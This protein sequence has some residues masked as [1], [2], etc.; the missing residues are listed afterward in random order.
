LTLHLKNHFPFEPTSDQEV[1]IQKIEDF[2][3][4]LHKRSALVIKG[5]AGTGKTTL[6]GSLVKALNSQ[7]TPVILMAPTGRA[8][9]VMSEYSQ[10]IATTIHRGIYLFDNKDDSFGFSLK[11]N[12]LKNA[13]VI[14]D[15]SS[16]ISSSGGL[17]SSFLAPGQTL[18]D[19][20][21]Q[22]VFNDYNNKLILVGDDAQLPPVGS[23]Y[24]PA[25]NIDFLQREL[26][27]H[28][29]LAELHKVTRQSQDSQ[30][31]F[32]ANN[33]RIQI[34]EKNESIPKLKCNKSDFKSLESFEIEEEIQSAY[35]LEGIE[36]TIII[37][38]SNRDANQLNQYVRFQ[39]LGRE[40]EIDAGDRL[41]VVKNNY[42]WLKDYDSP[43]FIANGEMIDVVKTGEIEEVYGLRFCNASVQFNGSSFEFQ[44]KLLLDTLNSDAPGLTK[45][46]FL[47][48]LNEIE[49]E[50]PFP[51]NKKERKKFLKEHPYYNA[52]QVKFGYAIT[53]HKAQG[54]QWNQVFFMQGYFT[55][56]HLD[57]GYLRWL[58]TGIT[59]AKKKLNLIN[60]H[61]DFISQEHT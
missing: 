40:G 33:L 39:M 53:C 36:E 26:N 10:H 43:Q 5:Y 27:I 21:C 20:L 54:G 46:V 32:N 9:K 34:Q 56:E 1:A 60:F 42:F 38:R 47:T 55:E 49:K 57:L 3:L 52:L 48:F 37:C 19:D 51:N 16:M 12:L 22:F 2:H 23:N 58:Y 11:R 17:G 59:R 50:M 61:H 31:L 28:A 35:H 15:E 7:D 25:L 29:E 44:T 24:S 45:E 30:I 14:I 13:T 8:A 18:L 41:M 4:N 6:I